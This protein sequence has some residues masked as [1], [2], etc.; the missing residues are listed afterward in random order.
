M[1]TRKL[2]NMSKLKLRKTHSKKNAKNKK[3]Q[4]HMKSWNEFC[5]MKK[6]V[7]CTIYF[8]MSCYKTHQKND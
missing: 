4:Y 7:K 1:C 6:N 2:K 8:E 3:K 5:A